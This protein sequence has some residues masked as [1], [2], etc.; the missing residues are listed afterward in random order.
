MPRFEPLND[1]VDALCLRNGDMQK[2]M[3]GVYLSVAR[4]TWI[5]MNETTL[6]I[7]ERVKVPLR[8]ICEINK[9]NNTVDLPCDY[10]RISSV[11]VI[12]H[13]GVFYPVFR[14]DRL[15]VDLVDVSVAKN[16]ACEYNCGYQLCN[17]IKGYEAVT[18]VKSDFLPDGS[19]ISFTCVDRKACDAN[20]NVYIETQYPLRQYVSSVWTNTVMTTEQKQLCKVEIDA[21]G[22]I[23]DTEQNIKDVCNACGINNLPPIPIGGNAQTPPSPQDNTWLYYCNSQMSF[24]EFQCGSPRGLKHGCE[25]IYNISELGNKLIFPPNFGFER[26]M[27]RYYADIELGNLQIPYMAKTCFM[28]GLQYFASINNEKKI[29]IANVFQQRY[30]NQKWGLLLELNKYRIQELQMM[31]TPPVY[32]PSFFGRHGDHHHDRVGSQF[33]EHGNRIGKYYN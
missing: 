1:V 23:C 14:N 30:A 28:T 18:S 27:I 17:L 32:V 5:D 12:D 11:N 15:H 6:K 24:F 19:P 25:N 8:K 31:M 4:D 21:H 3:K 2:R 7:A 20:G 33:D 13:N 26:V 16:C 10:L 9:R 22:C 29:P